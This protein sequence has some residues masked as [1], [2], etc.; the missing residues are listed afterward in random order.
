MN[1]LYVVTQYP[2][3][4]ETFVQEEIEQH[5]AAGHHVRVLSCN[6]ATLV[7][8]RHATA[9]SPAAASSKPGAISQLIGALP[10]PA[11]LRRMRLQLRNH[12]TYHRRI[13]PLLIAAN[14]QPNVIHAH[15]GY[16]GLI[17]C[18]I[19]QHLYKQAFFYVTFH[20]AD[21][22]A[23]IKRL[24]NAVYAPLFRHA[25]RLLTVNLP[26]RDTLIRCGAA[27]EKVTLHHVGINPALA[28][29][30]PITKATS[31]TT[32]RLLSIGRL[33]EKKGHADL[34]L[35]I[36]EI[37]KTQPQLRFQ[38]D[39]IGSGEQHALLT[40]MIGQLG[41]SEYVRLL[42]SMPHEQSIEHIRQCDI[43]VLASKTAKNG[44]CE[45]IPVVLMEAMLLQKPV[46]STQHSGIPELVTHEVS[47]VLVPEGSPEAL[48]K[49]LALLLVQPQRWQL[50]G[51]QGK[52]TVLEQFN[53]LKQNS[54]L[55]FIYQ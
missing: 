32:V 12:L 25:D 14:W 18:H 33:V 40:Q 19:K 35:A 30:A 23:Y 31:D 7:D 24:G 17:A 49:A 39:I 9:P 16:N 3:L 5:L 26:F 13:A 48:A 36:A 15:F 20:G 8:A 42:G 37:R 53:S 38:L 51:E 21:A 29:L 10:L 44:D 28:E 11:W 22:S 55:L 46:V 34:L 52:T 50:M 1:I 43:F 27:P 2:I 41:L 45:G 6:T 47:G 54:K 4:T